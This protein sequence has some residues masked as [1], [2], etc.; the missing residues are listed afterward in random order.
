HSIIV[1]TAEATMTLRISDVDAGEGMLSGPRLVD[2]GS[3]DAVPQRVARL[4]QVQAI[5]DE[6]FGSRLAVRT[7][8]R[9]GDVCVEEA[10]TAV[11]TRLR[12]FTIGPDQVVELAHRR[13]QRP[14]GQAGLDRQK[15]DAGV[16]THGEHPVD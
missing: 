12:A 2:D 4:A 1:P 5:V 16:G 10:R 3:H 15:D 14:T 11:R 9:T 7:E 6:Q 8:H 13:P